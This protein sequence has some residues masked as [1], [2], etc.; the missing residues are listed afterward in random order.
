MA[1]QAPLR[2]RALLRAGRGGSWTLTLVRH[3]LRVK[4]SEAARIIRA[5]VRLGYIAPS[6]LGTVDE[7]HWQNT[8]EGNAFANARASAPISRVKAERLVE[9]LLDRVRKVN[10]EPYY[11]YGVRR[12]VVFG[13]FLG[14]KPTLGDIDLVIELEAK[15]RDGETHGQLMLERGAEART[16]G[17][18]FNTWLDQLT[19]GETEVLRFLRSGSRY[20]SFHPPDE[21]I[22]RTTETRVLYE[23]RR[24]RSR[25][26]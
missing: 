17:R 15:E 5:L 14:T 13:S 2:I 1:G 4:R 19:W 3:E 10:A 24:P 23:G 7:P 26:R 22:L 20:L 25:R 8:L 9:E 18:R 12:V 6:P 21:G 11:L 16:G